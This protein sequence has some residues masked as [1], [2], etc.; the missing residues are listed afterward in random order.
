MKTTFAMA[1]AGALLAMLVGCK[2]KPIS[3]ADAMARVDAAIQINNPT[4]RDTALGTA[5]RSAAEAGA[6]DAVLKGVN[7]IGNPSTRDEVEED[8]AI[9]LRDAG[10]RAA[11]GNVAR[12]IGN[13][14]D[15]DNVLKK[16]ASD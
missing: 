7:K 8:C 6:D 3:A 13:P 1:F 14:S 11:A 5:C 12:L 16:L 4:D 9:K 15:R 10:K 2:S